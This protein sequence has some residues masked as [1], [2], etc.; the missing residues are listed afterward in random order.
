MNSW[1]EFSRLLP[2]LIL[3]TVFLFA[4]AVLLYDGMRSLIR[5]LRSRFVEKTPEEEAV[6][7]VARHQGA[8]QLHKPG[9]VRQRFAHRYEVAVR[10]HWGAGGRWR[11]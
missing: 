9:A 8:F 7:A 11:S 10:S 1:L 4:L 5:R 6:E 2:I 3:A